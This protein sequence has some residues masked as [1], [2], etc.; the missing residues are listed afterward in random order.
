MKFV[1]QKT[2]F[3]VSL[4]HVTV[5]RWFIAFQLLDKPDNSETTDA[6]YANVGSIVLLTVLPIL[7][8]FCL[9]IFVQV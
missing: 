4:T 5:R 1:W 7:C 2:V 6:G 9:C 8:M 3:L